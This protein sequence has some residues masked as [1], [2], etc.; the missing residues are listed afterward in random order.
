MGENRS[1]SSSSINSNL[2]DPINSNLSDLSD[3]DDQPMLIPNEWAINML[4][5]NSPFVNPSQIVQQKTADKNNDYEIQKEKRQKLEELQMGNGALDEQQ[6]EAQRG[7]KLL[8]H[9]IWYIIMLSFA[10]LQLQLAPIETTMLQVQQG[11]KFNFYY[12]NLA[13]EK[14]YADKILEKIGTELVQDKMVQNNK[15]FMD[16]IGE[17]NVHAKKV[18]GQQLYE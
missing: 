2:I 6:I 16:I 9:N 1:S 4:M 11:A 7:L 14:M 18:F 3:Y 5:D 13:L 10:I 17:I 12:L 15:L 8:L